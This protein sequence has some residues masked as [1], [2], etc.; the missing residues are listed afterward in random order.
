MRIERKGFPNG[1]FLHNGEADAIGE[2]E[3]GS[4]VLGENGEGTAFD[5]WW[6]AYD[7]ELGVGRRV[8]GEIPK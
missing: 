1:K 7:K 2:R 8:I 6:G 3:S 5:F 4:I